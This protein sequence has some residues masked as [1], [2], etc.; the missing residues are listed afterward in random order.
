MTISEF[1]FLLD[2]IVE[3]FIFSLQFV[4]VSICLSVY[5]WVYL[6]VYL[7]VCLWVC[8]LF[9]AVCLCVSVCLSG[10]LLENKIPAKRMHR[11]GSSFHW[12]VTYC[13]D[14]DPISFGALGRFACEFHRN[15]INGW[16]LT[17]NRETE[18][19]KKERHLNANDLS[20]K[21]DSVINTSVRAQ[22]VRLS[23]IKLGSVYTR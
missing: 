8:L 13:T 9:N 10:C 4:C 2:E 16:W 14:L 1:V 12:A 5:L 6:Y 18:T 17:P 7:W 20:D 19:N 3:G 23:R 11:F 22:I 21:K 15:Q